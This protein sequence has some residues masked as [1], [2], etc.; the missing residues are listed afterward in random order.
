ME[1][2]L[3]WVCVIIPIHGFDEPVFLLDGVII[4]T[5]RSDQPELLIGRRD[6]PVR[7]VLAQLSGGA[8][9][10]YRA[11][12]GH[13]RNSQLS[14]DFKYWYFDETHRD[15]FGPTFL[16]PFWYEYVFVRYFFSFDELD[17]PDREPHDAL[18]RRVLGLLQ[19]HLSEPGT[20]NT[21]YWIN[22][23][24]PRDWSTAGAPACTRQNYT[25]S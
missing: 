8:E 21:L 1:S 5:D 23:T 14:N 13:L 9:H 22:C 11:P 19:G 20:K 3:P 2:C 7:L 17:F 24:L 10:V 15:I 12:S 6:N 4:T 16:Y 18:L 25:Y